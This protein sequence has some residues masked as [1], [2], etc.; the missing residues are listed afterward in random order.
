MHGF[1]HNDIDP[2][3]A[4]PIRSLKVLLRS[5]LSHV[6]PRIQQRIEQVFGDEFVTGSDCQQV[7]MAQWTQD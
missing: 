3:D 1:E 2:H 5:N 6:Q 7:T 4:I